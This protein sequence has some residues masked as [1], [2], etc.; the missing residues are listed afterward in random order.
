MLLCFS[1]AIAERGVLA[2]EVSFV[3]EVQPI[4]ESSCVHC[5]NEDRSEG[6]FRLDTLEGAL[7]GGDNGPAL[8]PGKADESSLYTLC[9]V[10]ADDDS[11]MPPEEAPLSPWQTDR[12]KAW[13]NQGAKW[14]DGVTLSVKPRIDF[15]KN[16]QPILE[17]NC[18]S[19]HSGE[20]PE[21]GYDI[22]TQ[23]LAFSGGDQGEAIIPFEPLESLSF[24]TT[25][26][27]ED[28]D[29]LMPPSDQGGPLKPEE[30]DQL[31]QWIT[32]GAIWP[33]DLKLKVRARVITKKDTPDNLELVERLHALIVETAEKEAASTEEDYTGT[34]PLTGIEYDMVAIPGGD[35]LMGSPATEADRSEIE[36]PQVEVHVEVPH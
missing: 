3:R 2:Q 19:C 36:G 35:F 5:H 29:L 26:L 33:A 24:T 32:Q 15:V 27:D 1:F 22:T 8:V 9:V 30:I 18:V 17:V 20:D 6:E 11:I 14:P 13:I 31:E 4:L 23:S 25:T 34:I 7:A 21:A 10:P 16:I 28:D 12:L